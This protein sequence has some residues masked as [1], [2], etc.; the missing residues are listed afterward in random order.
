VE[1]A[2]LEVLEGVESYDWQRIR[3]VN[4]SPHA[5]RVMRRTVP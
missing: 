1:R 5:G 4:Q 3:Q 2:E